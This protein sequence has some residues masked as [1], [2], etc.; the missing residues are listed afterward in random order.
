MAVEQM[1]RAVVPSSPASYPDAE[2]KNLVPKLQM[3]ACTEAQ[4][5]HK[6]L[7]QMQQQ[8]EALS[9]K[10]AEAEV[11]CLLKRDRHAC[12]LRSMHLPALGFV[13]PVLRQ[14]SQKLV[15]KLMKGQPRIGFDFSSKGRKVEF[16]GR[17][18][19]LLR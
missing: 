14:Q 2:T 13:S 19:A 15:A 18:E 9:V 3:E 10:L 7:V 6:R 17:K 8:K 1:H 12:A 11:R 5:L 4:A 16:W